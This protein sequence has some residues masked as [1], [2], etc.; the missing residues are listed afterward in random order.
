M[1][2]VLQTTPAV[3]LK[4]EQFLLRLSP[5]TEQTVR[6]TMTPK[7]EFLPARET[8]NRTPVVVCQT[9]FSDYTVHSTEQTLTLSL[10]ACSIQV[11]LTSGQCS[12]FDATGA[13]LVKEPKA[14]GKY[15]EKVSVYRNVF[16][17]EDKLIQK[18][19]VDGMKVV[20]EPTETVFDR[21][22]Y[23]AKV[24]FVFG[25]EAI[26]GFGSHEEGYGNLRGKSRQI[27]QQNMKACV[28]CMMSTNGY[29]FL[30]DCGSLMT[31]EDNG[32]GSY[33][34][35]D[36]VDELDYYFFAGT[37]YQKLLHAYRT[38]TGAVPMLPKWA[39]GYGQS[40]ERYHCADELIDIVKEYRARKIPLSFIIQDWMTWEEG[41]WGQ[42][43]FDAT[44]YPDPKGLTDILHDMG[45]AMMISVWPNMNGMG[46][47]QKE[48]L[49]NGYMLGNQSTYNAFSADARAMYWKQAN[50]GIF[51]YGVDAWWC[52]CS[53]PFEADWHGE[54][55]PEPHERLQINVGEAKK[56][57]DDAQISEYSLCHSRGIYEGQ[58]SV[59]DDKRVVN[60]TRSSF[61]GQGRYSAITWSGDTSANWE[62]LKRQIPEGLNFCAAGEPYWSMDI[63]GFF[64]DCQNEWFVK[65]DYPDGCND[66]GY[67]ELYTRWLQYGTF[68]P[69]MRSHGTNTPREIW[70]FGEP[71]TMFY[72]AIAKFIRLRMMLM[73]YLYSQAAAVSM[74]S[75]TFI[76]ALGL[77]FPNDPQT[78]DIRDQFLFGPSLMVCPVTAPMYYESGSVPL[79]DVPK[80]RSV[81]LPAGCGWYDFFTGIYYAGGQTILA[82]APIDKIPLFIKAGAIVP[83]GPAEQ[84]PGEEEDAVITLHI[85]PG[86][87]CSFSLYDD[88]GDSYRY[89]QG[90][91]TVTPLF[92]SN[93]TNTLTI[94]KRQGSFPKMK[95][96]Q[97]YRIV[98]N[99]RETTVTVENGEECRITL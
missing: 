59:T 81:Y 64:T 18:E 9:S 54:L 44:R 22:A 88:A 35:M 2:Q 61:A 98:L 84:Y 26:Y 86:S 40:K 51:Q 73:P 43:S 7:D 89:E 37:S 20:T 92:F 48:F 77:A 25:N 45:A 32:Y 28:P 74:K 8:K 6:I 52:D 31:F 60:L 46:E 50:E 57:L 99:G 83:M 15:M 82:D 33:V 36:T 27:Y 78:F 4:N 90:E 42:K 19:T 66:L 95:Q 55:R 47:N 39:F 79:A 30:F 94:G 5:I 10:P 16:S 69:M 72:D 53:E 41:K 23:H 21:T 34:W 38:L 13:L 65:G 68:L 62:T 80:Q 96:S 3:V 12:Y 75:D 76:T 91:Y 24:S 63:G 97:Q 67:R 1:Y 87:D 71:G 11:D 93:E 17:K 14:N 58:R 49:A 56:Y 70:R 85:Y 29:G